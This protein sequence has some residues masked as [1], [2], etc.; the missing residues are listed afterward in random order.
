[1]KFILDLKAL[2][3][4]WKFEIQGDTRNGEVDLMFPDL[5]AASAFIS[6][7]DLG[8]VARLTFP[9]DVTDFIT[10]MTVTIP[11]YIERFWP[12]AS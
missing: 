3:K 11:N 8:N 10:P 5:M 12:V 6:S 4:M 2:S 1:M 7:N 9:G